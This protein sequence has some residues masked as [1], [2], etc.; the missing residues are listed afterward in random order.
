MKKYAIIAMFFALFASA[1]F[2]QTDTV[3]LVSDTTHVD[4]LIA[5]AAGDKE[6]IPVLVLEN[7]MLS[8]DINTQLTDLGVR[9]VILVGG[10]V[11][12]K[13]EV[14]TELEGF[15]YNV[16]RLWGA[17]RTGTA[18]EVASY[19]WKGGS[20]CIVLADDTK[21]SDADSETQSEASQDASINGCPF[22]P[23]PIGTIPAEVLDL[24]KSLNAQEARFVGRAAS[25]EFRLKLGKLRMIELIGN[26]DDV[27]DRLDDEAGELAH[28]ASQ[29]LKLVIV[30][31]PNWKHMLGFGG[32]G[33][34]H[35]LVRIVSN[36]SSVPDL[37]NLVKERNITTVFV[38]GKP[39]LAQDIANQL[40]AQGIDVRQISGENATDV[41]KKAVNA[42]IES[43]K[44]MR[45]HSMGND[46]LI[47]QQIKQHLLDYLNRTES[48]LNLLEAEIASLNTSE[49]NQNHIQKIQEKIDYAQSQISAMRDNIQNGNFETARSRMAKMIDGVN[50]LR[51]LYRIELKIDQLREVEE[52]ENDNDETERENDVSEIESRLAQL[53]ARCNA[54]S[55]EGLITKARSI[56]MLIEEAKARGDFI[57]SAELL[58]ELRGI[59]EQAKHLGNVCERAGRISEMLE[60]IAERRSGVSNTARTIEITSTGFGPSTITIAK[61]AAV[62]WLN[63][64]TAGHWPASAV[65]PTHK[66]YPGSDIAKCG[67]GEEIFDACK[68]LAQGESFTFRFNEKG[69]WQYHDHVTPSMFG[70]VNVV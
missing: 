28:N 33:G 70:T 36:T 69:T 11:V 3:I 13:P 68:G 55:I 16:V 60:N 17:E 59:V 67:T 29:R 46:T 23:V 53:R 14:Q 19:F 64:D 58:I 63:K 24:M 42:T 22:I 7:G 26:R 65:H 21:N 9:T 30:A 18:V 6:G 20:R 41:S 62:M 57:H 25:A 54:N 35:T 56:R 15:G 50:F 45:R 39:E 47:R 2:A 44:E 66:V 10:P 51:W 34:R 8:A 32:H 4:M 43:W 52:E 27:E 12:V 5:K 48:R 40:E 37:V 61:G 49:V 1:A 31:A 38:V